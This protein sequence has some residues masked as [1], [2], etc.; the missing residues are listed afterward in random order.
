VRRGIRP[1]YL[2]AFLVL[3]L[4][5]VVP[6]IV[7][8]SVAPAG[9]SIEIVDADGR[10]RTATTREIAA[11]EPLCRRGS[12]ENQF[13][14]WRD[15]GEYCGVLLAELIGADAAYESVI[16][17]AADG[18]RAE[19]ERWRIEDAQYPVVL[20]TSFDGRTVPDWSDGYRVAVLPED[21]D[22]SNAEYGA[23]SAGSFWVKNV[24]R[25]I[26]NP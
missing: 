9:P 17:V 26:L 8:W 16:V 24:V 13:G 4:L 6:I 10:T 1:A 15:E 21:G 19:I 14:T 5:V 7:R 22:V 23:E 18:Y 3:V 20:A 2:L 11:F 12:Y 25:L